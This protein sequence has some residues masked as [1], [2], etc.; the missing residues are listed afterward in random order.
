MKVTKLQVY[1]D[2]AEGINEGD[3]FTATV[4]SVE[5]R[6][7]VDLLKQKQENPSN[8]NK[9]K[10]DAGLDSTPAMKL[11]TRISGQQATAIMNELMTRE[12]LFEFKD[13]TEKNGGVPTVAIYLEEDTTTT[14]SAHRCC[15]IC[16]KSDGVLVPEGTGPYTSTLYIHPE[17]KERA[18]KAEPLIRSIAESEPT[19][20]SAGKW[21]E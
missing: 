16:C 7:V 10:T 17:C 6:K 4:R 5:G 1:G 13:E 8:S 19:T 21:S 2:E 12:V 11:V 20:T 15:I 14:T 9:R 3:I 18:K